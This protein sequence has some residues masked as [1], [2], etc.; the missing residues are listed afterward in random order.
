MIDEVRVYNRALTQAEIQTDMATPCGT[1]SRDTTPPTA[2]TS[3]AA[4]AVSPT[5]VDLT[6]T[7][8]TDNVGSDRLPGRALPGRRLHRPSPRSGHRPPPSFNNT[9]LSASTAYRTASAP[10]TPPA[11]SASVQLDRERH[12]TAGPDTTPPTAPT[13]LAANAVSATQVNLTWTA[14]TDNVAVTGYRVERCQGA[15]CTTFTQVGTPTGTTF[16]DTGLSAATTYRYRVRA[17]DAA[18]NLGPYS[19]DRAAPRH[20]RPPTPRRRRRRRACRRRR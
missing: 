13:G 2:P 19:A 7:A 10:S 4:N 11:T 3:L 8:A 15:G 17:V 6:W 16:T 5:Q 12:D 20:R 1:A 9:G 14:A 18:G